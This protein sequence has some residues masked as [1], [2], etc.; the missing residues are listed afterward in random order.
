MYGINFK[1]VVIAIGS[2]L[3]MSVFALWAWNT[4][5]ELYNFPMAQYKHVLAAAVMVLLIRWR[6]SPVHRGFK[7]NTG[8]AN[9][10]AN[11]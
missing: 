10:H 4:L 8:C 1:S 6:I 5:S 3:V 11:N 7:H 2:F 9:D